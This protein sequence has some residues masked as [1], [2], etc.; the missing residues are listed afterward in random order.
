MHDTDDA[1]ISSKFAVRPPSFKAA[2]IK[3]A[4]SK[5]LPATRN[6][7]LLNGIRRVVATKDEICIAG[8]VCTMK[9][10][11]NNLLT[12]AEREEAQPYEKIQGR[13]YGVFLGCVFKKDDTPKI[14]YSNL[15]KWFN[16]YLKD[17]WSKNFFDGVE[18]KPEDCDR[19]SDTKNFSPNAECFAAQIYDAAQFDDIYRRQ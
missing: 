7:G 12:G 9:Y 3:W 16:K 17:E 6:I 5:I 18:S 4:R 8:I 2:E 10:F 19:L 14:I 11:V 1:E 15:W 13:N